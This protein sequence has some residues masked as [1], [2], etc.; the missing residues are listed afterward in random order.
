[1][2]CIYIYIYVCDIYIYI[3]K[4]R[5]YIYGLNKSMGYVSPTWPWF[6]GVS[7]NGLPQKNAMLQW[8]SKKRNDYQP[9]NLGGTLFWDQ[10]VYVYIYI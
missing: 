2:M 1:M 3:Y 6:L 10:P 8:D 9:S 7:E 4:W 5:V